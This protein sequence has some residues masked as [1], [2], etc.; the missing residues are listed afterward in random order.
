[1]PGSTATGGGTPKQK[2]R[3]ITRAC[4]YCHG[5]SIRCRPQPNG[6]GC[7]NCIRF[8]QA[9]TF[10]RQAKRRGAPPRR[11]GPARHTEDA[12]LADNRPR[13]LPEPPSSTDVDA[14]LEQPTS[15][16]VRFANESRSVGSGCSRSMTYG[17]D[18]QYSTPVPWRAPDVSSQ[19]TVVDLVELYFEIVYPI[20]P[21]FHQ[22]SFVR[23]ISRAEYTSDPGLFALTMS[24]CSLVAAR[25]RDGAVSSS[26]RNFAALQQATPANFYE[27]AIKQ[28]CM[29]KT[30]PDLTILQA[31][32][33]LALAAIQGLNIRN[34]HRHLGQYHT[35]TAVYGLHDE[36]NWPRNIGTVEM[37]ER[38]RL[39]WSIYT[40]DVFTSIAWGGVIRSRE[41]QSNVQYPTVA[42]DDSFDDEG[43]ATLNEVPSQQSGSSLVTS[44]IAGRNFVTDLYRLIENVIA[45][46]P[47]RSGSAFRHNHIQSVL[48]E[49]PNLS[50]ERVRSHVDRMYSDL[51]QCFKEVKSYTHRPKLD[52]FGFQTADIIATLQ[53]L[54][55]VLLSAT[56]ATTSER[57]K[58]ANEVL[59]AFL[60]VPIEYHHA[61]SVPLLFHLA[62]IA[63]LLGSVLGQQISEGDYQNIR[64]TML[65]MSHMLSNLEG[66]HASKG[67]S[68]RLL[69]QVAKLDQHMASGRL[70]YGMTG[71]PAQ[72]GED[73]TLEHLPQD[74]MPP[75]VGEDPLDLSPFQLP[76]ELLGN[77]DNI[78]DIQDVS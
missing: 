38:R 51:P 75:L 6:P 69:D 30:R 18:E 65:S 50:Y 64:E 67:A 11:P 16:P 36:A 33:V 25:V 9:C 76:P 28:P 48:Q 68:E 59:S 32:A 72:P 40:L 34:M 15:S 13:G 47:A 57:C 63:Q 71:E 46:S 10:S 20:F 3:R 60:A 35:L 49:T 8:G 12:D 61:I 31:H 39:F 19:A 41:Q 23:R 24:V 55:M 74:F 45:R 78:F 58:V 73:S 17:Y 4:D 27:Q 66:L 21:L 29:L 5:R 14:Q 77:F 2:Q 52:R 70:A 62:V 43:F 42:D 56:G 22:P 26:R 44:W 7:E 1:M 37:E 53:L 54:S